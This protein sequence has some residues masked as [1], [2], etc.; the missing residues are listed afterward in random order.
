M[1]SAISHIFDNSIFVWYFK[2]YT[3]I[4]FLKKNKTIYN[5]FVVYP[6]ISLIKKSAN[7]Y[8]N[9]VLVIPWK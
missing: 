7:Y 6:K 9:F 3:P 2:I 4:W 5:T 1:N 8:S